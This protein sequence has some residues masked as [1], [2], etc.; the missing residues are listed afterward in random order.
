MPLDIY[1]G[2]PWSDTAIADLKHAVAAGATLEETAS[3]LCRSGDPM[4]VAKKA[5]ELGL[6][7]QQGGRRRKP[8]VEGRFQ[9]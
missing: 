2:Q 8:K 4:A 7:W 3:F 5:K 6:R 1:D 9:P